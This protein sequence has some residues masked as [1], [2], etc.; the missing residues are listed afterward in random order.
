[1][2]FLFVAHG[3]PNISRIETCPSRRDCERRNDRGDDHSI[4]PREIAPAY[5]NRKSREVM[6]QHAGS[7]VELNQCVYSDSY[8]E[9]GSAQGRATVF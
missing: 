6:G 8:A 1:M 7:D 2:I 5:V 4:R 9:C 3:R